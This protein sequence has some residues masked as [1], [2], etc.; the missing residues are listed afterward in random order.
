MYKNPKILEHAEK[1]AIAVVNKDRNNYANFIKIAEKYAIA[2]WLIVTGT[3]ALKLLLNNNENY[4][5][6]FFSERSHIHARKMAMLLYE[7]DPDNL[8]HYV[9]VIT[10]IPDVLITISVNGRDMFNFISLSVYRGIKVISVLI[11][12]S[13]RA[14]FADDNIYCIGPEIQLIKIYTVLCNPAQASE[15]DDF[16]KYEKGVR[17]FYINRRNVATLPIQEGGCDGGTPLSKN[18]EKEKLIESL[19]SIYLKSTNRIVIGA[20]AISL[21]LKK[22]ID[23]QNRLQAIVIGKFENEIADLEAI[24]S[25]IN[26]PITTKIDDPRLPI[27]SRLRRMTIYYDGK[28]AIMDIFNSA[29]FEAIPYTKIGNFKVGIPFV[30]MRFK[31]IDMW[32]MQLLISLN[33]VEEKIGEVILRGLNKHYMIIS[34][35]L[36]KLPEVYKIPELFLGRIENADLKIKRE[37]I[38]SKNKNTRFYPPFYPAA[39]AAAPLNNTLGGVDLYEYEYL[40]LQALPEEE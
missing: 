30:I 15:W 28:D 16:L 14:Q 38:A 1:K 6:D 32:T 17:E 40:P 20:F 36:H 5:Y 10:K 22:Y 29:T 4:Q 8:G 21:I 18:E 24:A 35:E 3:S 9:S 33:F 39:A 31:L 26:I 13:V 34:S 23:G 27:E 37:I 7:S 2:N 19:K 11:P 25:R 12:Q